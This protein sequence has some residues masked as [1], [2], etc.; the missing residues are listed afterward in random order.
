M[1]FSDRWSLDELVYG[2]PL[3]GPYQTKLPSLDDIISFIREDREGQVTRIRHQE[4]VE[5]ENLE[6][7][8]AQEEVVIPLSPPP[9]MNHLHLI[10]T[11]M[12]R[13]I[14]KGPRVQAPRVLVTCRSVE[15]RRIIPDW[16]LRLANDRVGLDKHPWEEVVRSL[17]SP[18]FIFYNKEK[19]PHICHAC[20]LGKLTRDSTGMFLSQ[21][22]Y[23]IELLDR[24]H[25]ASCN[26][27]RTPFDTESKLG[28]DGDP[29]S[30]PTLYQKPHFSALKRIL[31][32]VRGTLDF[33]LQIY[34]SSTSSLMAYSD[35][36]WVDCPTTRRSTSGYCVFFEDN[37]LSWSCKRQHTLS[38]SSADAEYRG[39]ANVVAETTRLRNLLRE[40]HMPLLSATFVY[41]DNVIAIYLTVI[42]IQHQRT[43]HIE[44]NIHFV[45][46]MVARGQVRVLHVPSHY[47]YADIFTKGLPSTL[48]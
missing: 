27:T 4:E 16:I 22:K 6:M 3:E 30:N 9:S 37:L 14:M 23:A 40:L 32:Y 19:S 26:P 42:P 11:M 44:I 2:A 34:A 1:F 12:M 10:S 38:R 46:D 20:Q 24:A 31:E 43:K 13:E 36:D 35:A 33:E 15:G 18:H 21:K 25:M 47:R 39:V 29:I 41:C 8:V 45:R 5:S 17:V 48:F 7:I 28:A